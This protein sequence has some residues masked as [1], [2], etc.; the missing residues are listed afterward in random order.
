MESGGREGGK[1][2]RREGGKEGG[3]ESRRE[4]ELLD[5]YLKFLSIQRVISD[6]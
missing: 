2:G 5:E 3:E 6:K 1:E 4:R